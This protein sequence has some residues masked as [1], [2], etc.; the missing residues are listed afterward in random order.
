M[1]KYCNAGTSLTI[2][3]DKSVVPQ[4]D[5]GSGFYR[6]SQFIRQLPWPTSWSCA[7]RRV[8]RRLAQDHNAGSLL[9]SSTPPPPPKTWARHEIRSY[10]MNR[11]H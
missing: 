4:N 2:S 10:N 6:E 9:N 8:T 1:P 3:H 7:S 11:S 5:L